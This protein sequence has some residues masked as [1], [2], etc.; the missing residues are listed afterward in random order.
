MWVSDVQSSTASDSSQ[1]SAGLRVTSSFLYPLRPTPF[2][3]QVPFQPAQAPGVAAM[4]TQSCNGPS[5]GSSQEADPQE[6]SW[7]V[8]LAFTT[9]FQPSQPQWLSFSSCAQVGWRWLR[10][11]VCFKEGVVCLSLTRLSLTD[12]LARR[13]AS[14]LQP[15][16]VQLSMPASP[17]HSSS[18]TLILTQC[19]CILHAGAASHCRQR[20]VGAAQ[21]WPL[22][23]LPRELHDAIVGVTN[24]G[25]A[26]DGVGRGCCG[27]CLVHT[28]RCPCPAAHCPPPAPLPFPWSHLPPQASQNSSLIPQVDLAGLLDDAHALAVVR[29]LNI[30]VFLEVRH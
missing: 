9:S 19:R 28:P 11:W 17:A 15:N 24:S 1:S 16:E 18:C 12:I 5:G 3:P 22:R 7:W 2:C 23:L 8:P 6:A 4:R 29:Q 27:S 14:S 20:G 25:E 30:T 21:L 26:C 10:A 13:A